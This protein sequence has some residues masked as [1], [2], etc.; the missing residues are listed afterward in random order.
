MICLWRSFE[1]W[2]SKEWSELFKRVSSNQWT[3][4]SKYSPL[5]LPSHC[6]IVANWF[7]FYSCPFEQSSFFWFFFFFFHLPQKS[8]DICSDPRGQ[9]LRGHVPLHQVGCKLWVIWRV[10]CFFGLRTTATTVFASVGLHEDIWLF[11][12]DWI[13]SWIECQRN[14]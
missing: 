4:S 2:R 7:R 10:D 5:L 13:G 11:C 8:F 6:I 14:R 12:F 9:R 3:L 1:N